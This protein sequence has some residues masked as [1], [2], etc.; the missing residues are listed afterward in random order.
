MRHADPCDDLMAVSA[1]RRRRG[2]SRRCRRHLRRRQLLDARRRC[3]AVA[4]VAHSG[5]RPS[6]PMT[7]PVARLR[8]GRRTRRQSRDPSGVTPRCRGGHS[9]VST[10]LGR[11]S[12]AE[13]RTALRRR[14]AIG[15]AGQRGT[16]DRAGQSKSGHVDCASTAS[17]APPGGP[18]LGRVAVRNDHPGRDRTCGSQ[19]AV[20]ARSPEPADGA[21]SSAPSARSRRRY[22]S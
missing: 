10:A 1:T 9:S 13:Y 8:H 16:S 22:R 14:R 17:V 3:G 4:A 18:D 2:S 11:R 5:A 12:S 15:A 7:R 6:A 19:P 20:A 21:G